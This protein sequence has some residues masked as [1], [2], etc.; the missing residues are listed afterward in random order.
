[1][2]HPYVTFEELKENAFFLKKIDLLNREL[3]SNKYLLDKEN[4]LHLRMPDAKSFAG[5]RFSAILFG[6]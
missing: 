6:F 2:F 5:E 4:S 3:I 1:M